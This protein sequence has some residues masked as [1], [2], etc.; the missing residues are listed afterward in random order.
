MFLFESTATGTASPVQTG[1]A[2]CLLFDK[3]SSDTDTPAINQGRQLRHRFPSTIS[4]PS[5]DLLSAPRAVLSCDQLLVTLFRDRKYCRIA[6]V[7]KS[8]DR[9]GGCG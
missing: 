6:Q 1:A 4:A 3:Q 5:R 8:W 9:R 2:D 7:T